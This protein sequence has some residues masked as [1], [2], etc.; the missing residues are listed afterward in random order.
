VKAMAKTSGAKERKILP[1]AQIL[2]FRN[3]DALN[4]QAHGNLPSSNHS[5]FIYRQ[6]RY[7]R[8]RSI[9]VTARQSTGSTTPM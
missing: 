4:T 3:E 1:L 5:T 9:A 6:E 2:L 7:S 8:P